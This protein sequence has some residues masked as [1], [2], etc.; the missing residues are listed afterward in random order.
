MN[1]AWWII[2]ISV[3]A[4]LSGLAGSQYGSSQ[5][6]RSW[7]LRWKNMELAAE[8]ASGEL[9]KKSLDLERK[10][11]V[12]MSDIDKAYQKG[13]EDGKLAN[14]AIADN[15]ES[16][17]VGLRKEFTC[18][19][20]DVP[21]TSAASR[22]RDAESRAKIQREIAAAVIRI[23]GECDKTAVQLDSCQRVVEGYRL[24]VNGPQGTSPAPSGG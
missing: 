11:S 21:D 9:S 10:L 8:K 14:D 7:E 12:A 22:K 13:I 6:N 3:V 5:T 24:L 17:H 2:A 18:P 23:G 1:T 15:V 20:S 16:G 4:A 19:D